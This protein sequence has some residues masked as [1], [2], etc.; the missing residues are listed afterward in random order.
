MTSGKV[1]PNSCIM[2]LRESCSLIL[3]SSSSL[4][5][6]LSNMLPK[7]PPRRLSLRYQGVQAQA[8]FSVILMSRSARTTGISFPSASLTASLSSAPGLTPV[9]APIRFWYEPSTRLAIR[10]ASCLF[11]MTDFRSVFF[12]RSGSL[13]DCMRPSSSSTHT[14]SGFSFSIVSLTSSLETWEMWAV[15]TRMIS[16]LSFVEI[17]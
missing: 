4:T 16:L 13:R 11:L 5:S 12:Q 15:P 1:L 7:S 17:R 8:L 10:V 14:V 9:W 3:A 6:V 2:T